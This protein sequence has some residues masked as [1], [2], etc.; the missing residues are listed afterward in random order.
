MST[1]KQL[2]GR[3]LPASAAM[4][5][6]AVVGDSREPEL[7]A[8]RRFV[9][10]G[11]TAVDIGAHRGS[12]TYWLSR[13]VGPSGRVHAYEP[14]PDLAATLR[15][16]VRAK[17]FANITVSELALG[18]SQGTARLT[19]PHQDGERLIGHA[20]MRNTG[21]DAAGADG[22]EVRT[23]RLDDQGLERVTFVKCDVEGF[24]LDV[25][26]GGLGLIEQQH[27]TLLIELEERHAGA[28]VLEVLELLGE[29]GYTPFYLGAGDTMTVVP[30][31]HRADPARLNRVETDHYV[32]NF[33]FVHDGKAG[34][35]R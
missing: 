12:Y 26:L 23:A 20:T 1:W 10:A 35:C 14:Q 24:E 17:R 30:P 34:T 4:Q 11:D 3:R 31:S 27:P 33:F 19:V 16:A 25:L 9:S 5:L 13:L 15:R 28:D 22:F 6:R 7:R 2:V 8:L 29:R 18:N 32:N 21:D